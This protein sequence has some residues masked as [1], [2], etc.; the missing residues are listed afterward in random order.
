M[1]RQ[2]SSG[3]LTLSSWAHGLSGEKVSPFFVVYVSLAYMEMRMLLARW[4]W[5]FDLE[6]VDNAPPYYGFEVVQHTS[7]IHVRVT[8]RRI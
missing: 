8:P 1:A 6:L 2:E 5:E 7:P 3:I 4:V